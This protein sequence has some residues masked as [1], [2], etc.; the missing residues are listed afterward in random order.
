LGSA[1]RTYTGRLGCSAPDSDSVLRNPL[2][3]GY[4]LAGDNAGGVLE[5]LHIRLEAPWLV[6][7]VLKQEELAFRPALLSQLARAVTAEISQNINSPR[8]GLRGVLVQA[9]LVRGSFVEESANP[10]PRALS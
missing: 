3:H 9:D 8:T 10:I 6:K 2:F 4:Q 5:A 1:E 7:G